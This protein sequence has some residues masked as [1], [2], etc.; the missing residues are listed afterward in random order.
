M[1]GEDS[2]PFSSSKIAHVESSMIEAGSPVSWRKCVNRPVRGSNRFSPP[3]PGPSP[4][5]PGAV[6][7]E[8]DHGV[9]ADR[10]RVGRIVPV[11]GEATRLAV[12]AVEAPAVRGDPQVTLRVLQDRSDVGLLS[13][14]RRA[15][16][17]RKR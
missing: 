15:R 11:V 13:A 14:S 5:L 9:A 2:S 3:L 6:L 17:L 16:R 8:C 1:G 7:V 4:D 10:A 12:A